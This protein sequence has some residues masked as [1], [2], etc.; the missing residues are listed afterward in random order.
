[1][2]QFSKK[3]CPSTNNN[4][5]NYS[6]YSDYI[7][8]QRNCNK[9]VVECAR[10]PQ[11]I[12]GPT[13]V[14]GS[15]TNTGATGPM[16]PTGYTG[17]QGVAGTATNTGATGPIGSIGLTGPTGYTGPQSTVTG[18]TGYTG[19]TG[20]TGPTGPQSTVTGPTGPQSTV[21]G[22][23]GNTG[24]TGPQS[25][26]TGPTGPVGPTPVAD[27]WGDYLYWNNQTTPGAWTVG[28]SNITIGCHAGEFNQGTNAV[29]LGFLAGQNSQGTNAVAI[30]LEAGNNNQGTFAVAIGYQAGNI[31]QGTNAIAIG[32]TAG[33]EVQGSQ[34][35]AIGNQAGNYNQGLSA[36]ALG[37]QSGYTSQGTFAT[38]IGYQ[39]GYDSQGL[40][41]VAIGVQSGYTSQGTFATAIGY[42][43]GY[44][45]QGT[46]AV[47]IGNQAG[48]QF[49]G[50]SSI[51]IGYAA[52]NNQ[53]GS[54]AIAIGEQ[55][56]QDTQR[57]TAIAIGFK[58]GKFAQGTSAVAIGENTATNNQGTQAIAIGNQAGYQSQRA[59]AVAIGFKA[60]N[61]DQGTNAV[62]LGN[63]AGQ[64]RQ[65]INAV[66]IGNKAGQTGQQTNSVA[67]GNSAG[68][69]LQQYSSI[70]IGNQAGNTYQGTNA[71]ALGYFAGNNSQG[72]NSI[73]I[74]ALAGA[75][76]QS[77]NSIILNATGALLNSA[78]AN[79]FYVAPIRNATNANS[80]FYDIT[81]KEITY[82]PGIIG[83]TGPTGRTGPTGP[84]STVTGPTG[85]QST[86]TGPTGPSQWNTAYYTGPTGPGYTGI[87]YTGDVMVFGNL[88]V[89]GAIDPTY[90]A[91][92]P[93]ITNPM[94]SGLNGIWVD[95][96][97]EKNLRTKNIYLND[98]SSSSISI[99]SSG[100]PSPSMTL[101]AFGINSLLEYDKLTFDDNA[102]SINIVDSGGE[103]ITSSNATFNYNT[104]VLSTGISLTQ[105]NISTSAIEVGAIDF[106]DGVSY[107]NN[108]VPVSGNNTKL[109]MKASSTLGTIRCFNSNIA[110]PSLADIN[111][112]ASSLSLN[113]IPFAPATTPNLAA[114][115]T[116][117]NIANTSINM[118]TN[119][120]NNITTMTTQQAGLV[121]IPQANIT[122]VSNTP[123]PVT[124]Y[125]TDHQV[126][127]RATDPVPLIDTFVVQPQNISSG[128]INCSHL[129]IGN[130]QWL[131]T[132]N[133]EVYMFDTGTNNWFLITQLD[134]PINAL[135]YEN[136]TG[137]L[138]I[139]GQFFNC[140]VPAPAGSVFNYI[141][142]IPS[143]TIAVVT[144]AEIFF[145]G[146]GT[147][148]FNNSVN[149]ITSDGGN[150]IY[151]GGD[152]TAD[153]T[154]ITLCSYFAVY[155]SAG[156][157][158][159]ALNASNGNGFDDSVNNLNY[160][161]G[162]V[163]A[164][165]AFSNMLYGGTTYSPYCITFQI[166][167]YSTSTIYPFDGGMGTLSSLIPGFD[168]IK[169]DG[170]DFY[171]G[172]GSNVYNFSMYYFFRLTQSCIP[173]AYGTPLPSP[174]T[175]FYWKA[176]GVI[177]SVDAVAYYNDGVLISTIPWASYIFYFDY[178]SLI[179]FN[180]QGVGSQWAFNGP[181]SN[182]FSLQ[183][184][185]VLKIGNGQWTNIFC[186][187]PYQ[188]YNMLINWNPALNFYV[189]VGVPF[190]NFG[191]TWSGN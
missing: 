10:G 42:Q 37:D 147:A 119:S 126:L 40:S 13:G 76:F 17:P 84:Q 132:I 138:Y 170:T 5:T 25:T 142:Y 89:S 26:V 80:L 27:C 150:N 158:L 183:N 46:N 93:Q 185:R 33:Y 59:N 19:P 44:D 140:I 91:L 189:P 36:V 65:G 162:V 152:F 113:S 39:A 92:E 151:F 88:Y 90:L 144:P 128:Y 149:A 6:N 178:G 169:N 155:Y 153:S 85:P 163:C 30:G 154:Y 116:V 124:A 87:G 109:S 118:N 29:A 171:V 131:G 143:P 20:N 35:V 34:A 28:D 82:G 103:V 62:A 94:P 174:L 64:S 181:T 191:G 101:S 31:D 56:G 175:N 114:V 51:S 4:T 2:S 125:G 98:G 47:A 99:K 86:V 97:A 69:Q 45:S 11:G 12:Q 105:T 167:G 79:A 120:I 122:A 146:S 107:T 117:A 8:S 75:T 77:E 18:P 137:F 157:N 15:A 1:M 43:A 145:N 52:G 78:T 100:V 83:N 161:G 182:W 72:T 168:L 121:F 38:A 173:I 176:P 110:P 160:L 96:T 3:C 127:L 16:G 49:Q 74:G 9:P 95:N 41:A 53:Q 14:S 139:G 130:G 81:N 104:T 184:G 57:A 111:F 136:S 73:A 179:Y 32:T 22:P 159:Y 60:G 48:G 148:G 172:A 135:F 166:S 165:G 21:T 112:E 187:T 68:A 24:P 50:S 70:A 156:N 188:G 7:N 63:Q 58:A 102:G 108:D 190:P 61:Q 133:G 129:S 186:A 115:L 177:Y 106:T 141:C 164:T 180:Y 134:G 67:I 55:T 71:V 23:T 123:T 54:N 66:A